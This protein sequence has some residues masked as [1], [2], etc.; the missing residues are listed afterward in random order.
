MKA[1]IDQEIEMI[2]MWHP[3]VPAVDVVALA[4]NGRACCRI[5]IADLDH[6]LIVVI[7]VLMMQATVMK[8]VDV[9]VVLDARMAAEFAVGMSAL[10]VDCV[11]HKFISS[12][13]VIRLSFCSPRLKIFQK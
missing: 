11:L 10:L 8:I 4:L 2:A 9:I 6:M 5:Y 13:S 3:F 12:N 1:T 7:A